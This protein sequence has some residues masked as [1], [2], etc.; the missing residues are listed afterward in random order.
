MSLGN[1]GQISAMRKIAEALAFFVVTALAWAKRLFA[2]ALFVLIT[3]MALDTINEISARESYLMYLQDKLKD[4]HEQLA[5]L[6]DNGNHQATDGAGPV[7]GEREHLRLQIEAYKES[8]SNLKALM[9]LGTKTVKNTLL[10]VR[11]TIESLDGNSEGVKECVH[12]DQPLAQG[13]RTE[14]HNVLV[15]YAPEAMSSENLLAVSILSCCLIG[16]VTGAVRTGDGVTVKSLFYGL[17]SGFIVF[18]AL[19]G[20]RH[21]FLLQADAQI[22]QYNPYSTGFLALISGLFTDK[23]F[24]LLGAVADAISNKVKT[25]VEK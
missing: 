6:S 12:T 8:I 2:V 11:C 7:D 23:T 18:L 24:E 15:N 4:F 1:E 13:V 5:D 10:G 14:G 16:S 20:G 19:K 22:V 9:F 3:T 25:V 17:S 21:V